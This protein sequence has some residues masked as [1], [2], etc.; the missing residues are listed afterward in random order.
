[1]GTDLAAQVARADFF[2][3]HGYTPIDLRWYAGVDQLGYSVVSQPIMALLGAR[4]TGALA[5]VGAAVALA[6]LL[7]RTGAPRPLLGSLLG[8]VTIA[9]NL[10]SGRVTYGLGVFLGLLALLL[11]TYRRVR[12]LSA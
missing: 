4:P 12:W 9:G 11:L 8:A 6:G 1:M 10:V 3:D 7:R 2:A 5:L